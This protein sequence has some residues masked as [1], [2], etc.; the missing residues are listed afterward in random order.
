MTRQR[1]PRINLF[2]YENDHGIVV[3]TERADK[4]FVKCK[5][6]GQEHEQSSRQIQRNA[7]S[8]KC[9][10]FKPHNYTGIAK[11]D[12]LIRRTYGITLEQYQELL[13]SQNNGCAIC[14]RTEE[15]DGR[16][17]AIDHDHQTGDVRGVLCNNCNNGLGSF[18][19]NIEQMLKAIDYLKNP[20]FK[21]ANAR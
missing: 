1:K 16:R 15:P 21:Y 11:D 18:S 4:W 12:A 3:R 17:L 8:R 6:C 5:S 19:D 7:A 13:I 2:G 10:N 9:E 14:G 20:P